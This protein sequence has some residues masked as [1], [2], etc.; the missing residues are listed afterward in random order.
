[1]LFAISVSQRTIPL[2]SEVGA[3]TRRRS[4]STCVWLDAAS[5]RLEVTVP[6]Q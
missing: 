4:V 1:M 3:F 5:S 2:K 6:G